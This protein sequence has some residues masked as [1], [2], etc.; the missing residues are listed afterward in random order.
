MRTRRAPRRR[1]A[2]VRCEE[3]YKEEEEG[4]QRYRGPHWVHKDRGGVP[5]DRGIHADGTH[6][7]GG[8]ETARCAIEF[9]GS[10]Q[11][12]IEAAVPNAFWLAAERPRGSKTLSAQSFTAQPSPSHAALRL[13]RKYKFP[14]GWLQ[15]PTPLTLNVEHRTL[16]SCSRMTPATDASPMHLPNVLSTSATDEV[17]TSF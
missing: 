13:L 7:T 15:L 3:G 9:V 12:Q 14:Q 8:P 4:Q 2:H 17:Q 1:V 10:Y 5:S 16:P 6:L 11:S